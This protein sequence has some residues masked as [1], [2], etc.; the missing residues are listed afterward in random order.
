MRAALALGLLLCASNARAER[1]LP[2]QVPSM[3]R[4]GERLQIELETPYGLTPPPGIQNERA[5]R[6]F[7]ARLCTEARCVPLAALDVRPRDGWSTF[8]RAEFGL[9]A[10]LVPGH[11]ELDVR[12]PGGLAGLPGGVTVGAPAPAVERVLPSAGCAVAASPGRDA[13]LG[14]LLVV[15]S[16]KLGAARR[17]RSACGNSPR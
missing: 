7:S 12:F 14:L 2:V 17:A 10:A 13:P 3:V 1:R 4:A 6:G 5:L 9:P 16:R 15:L 11:Y 8:Y